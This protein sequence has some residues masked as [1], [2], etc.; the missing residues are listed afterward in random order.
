V[1]LPGLA[2]LGSPLHLVRV[3]T[4]TLPPTLG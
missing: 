4:H 3:L 1:A 2:L